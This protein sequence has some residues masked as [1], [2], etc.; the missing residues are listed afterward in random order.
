[1]LLLALSLTTGIGWQTIDKLYRA[2]F[3]ETG[4]LHN[5]TDWLLQYPFLT[6]Q[7][8][9]NLHVQLQKGRIESA[10]QQMKKKG[11]YFIS[12]F[13]EDYPH[14]LSEIFDP[15]WVLFGKGDRSL[16]KTPGI[17][18][19][20]SRKTSA[21]GQRVTENIVPELVNDGWAIISGMAIGIDSIS[22]RSA[23]QAEGS[24]IAVLGSGIDNVYPRQNTHLYKQ[25]EQKGLI[26]S[27]YPPG[28][29]PHPSYFPRRNRIISGLSYGVVVVEAAQK[30]GSLIT[31]HTALEQGREVFAVPGN[32]FDKHSQGTNELIQ[33]QGAKLILGA[34]DI[35]DEFPYLEL[36]NKFSRTSETTLTDNLEIQVYS[37][38]QQEKLHINEIQSRIDLSLPELTHLLL[39]LELKGFITSLPGYYYQCI[40][41]YTEA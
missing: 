16:L 31:A 17:G 30:S 18:I 4:L 40:Q 39:K 15:P 5:H 1:M 29:Q 21:Y 35:K 33:K 38:L 28:T 32:I 19:V 24:T 13:D 7:Q 2:G 10:C 6:E 36:K 34:Q 8:A 12:R 11:I 27:E 23:L 22:H 14:L 20:G 37:L 25:L 3:S 26:L 41:L 9:K